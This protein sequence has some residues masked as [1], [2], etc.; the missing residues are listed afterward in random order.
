MQL[1]HLAKSG[2]RLLPEPLE[3]IGHRTLFPSHHGYIRHIRKGFERKLAGGADHVFVHTPRCAGLSVVESLPN[4]LTH[5]HLSVHDYRLALGRAGFDRLFK[6]GFVRN[7]WDRL[8][9]SFHHLKRGGCHDNDKR[10]ADQH[11]AGYTEF[12][13]FVKGWLNGRTIYSDVWHFVPMVRF[14]C[15]PGRRAHALDYLGRFET[16]ADDFARIARRLGR[17]ASLAHVNHA[18]R[19][20]ADYRA[21]YTPETRRIVERVYA[22]DIEA[23]G[24]SF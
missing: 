20:H 8:V 1:S 6:F 12:E 13:P 22:A 10:W 7:P 16:L 24:Y 18:P 4:G 5:S 19:A 21:Y 14:V 9:S 11:L 2:L 17:E 15:L 3:R 23:F